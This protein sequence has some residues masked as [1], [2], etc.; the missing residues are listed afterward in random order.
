MKKFAICAVVL[1]TVTI[2]IFVS[3]SEPRYHGRTLTSWLQQCYDTPLNET[4]RLQEAQDAVRAIGA[5]RALPKLL[6][7]VAA[8]DDP[9]S[10]RIIKKSEEWKIQFLHWHSATDFQ[11]LGIAGFEA[12]ETNA[13][14]AVGELTSLLA[15]K[16]HAF[17]AV[18]CLV[19]IGTPAE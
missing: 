6:K 3:T 9:A 1:L 2:A 14:P 15:D 7:L 11:Q 12:L 17:T 10:T 13:A 8:K 19:A 4:Q 16:Q 5:K 18:R